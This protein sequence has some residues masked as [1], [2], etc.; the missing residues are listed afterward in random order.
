MILITRLNI[1]YFSIFELLI[2]ELFHLLRRLNFQ[3]KSSTEAVTLQN[4]NDKNS[5]KSYGEIGERLIYYFFKVK[6]IVMI[7][8]E[9]AQAFEALSFENEQDSEDL[10]TILQKINEKGLCETAYARF[11]HTDSDGIICEIDDCRD[12]YISKFTY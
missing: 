8:Y 5:E 2:H 9:A 7:T 3:L 6:K 12:Y 10:K 11:T 4:S 1:I